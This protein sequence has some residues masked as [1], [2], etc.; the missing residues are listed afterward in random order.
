[1]AFKG[2]NTTNIYYQYILSIYFQVSTAS[3][4]SFGA[5]KLDDVLCHDGP[6][7][8]LNSSTYVQSGATITARH[9][10]WIRE[11]WYCCCV[12]FARIF[13]NLH[14]G[15]RRNPLFW[16]SEDRATW[17]ILIT[18]PT[19]CTNFSNLFLEWNCSSILNPL[20]GLSETCRVPFQINLRN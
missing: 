2:L 12:L 3:M 8:N 6:K 16:H 15:E 9:D 13:W 10:I 11:H 20:A 4:S 18:K 1:M 5:S 7:R 19:S 17:Y 14:Y